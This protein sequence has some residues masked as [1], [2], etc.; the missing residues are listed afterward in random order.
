M[1]QQTPDEK[2]LDYLERAI[3]LVND[4]GYRDNT[5]SVIEIAKMLQREEK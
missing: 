1:K 3:K 5:S 2:V 4:N